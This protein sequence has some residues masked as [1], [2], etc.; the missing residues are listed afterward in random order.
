MKAIILF[1]TVTGIILTAVL[2]TPRHRDMNS[3]K[4]SEM[5]N[6]PSGTTEKQGEV[7]VITGNTSDYIVMELKDARTAE[8]TVTYNSTLGSALH[9]A[10]KRKDIKTARAI[11]QKIMA[12]KRAAN[13][14]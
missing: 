5:L 12:E 9:E 3:V 11:V 4:M 13:N 7:Y 8:T 14:E 1:F 2:L 10:V 6:S